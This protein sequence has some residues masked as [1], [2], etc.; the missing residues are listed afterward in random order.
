MKCFHRERKVPENIGNSACSKLGHVALYV[1][2]FQAPR[3]RLRRLRRIVTIGY[4]HVLFGECDSECM[5]QMSGKVFGRYEIRL[6][7]MRKII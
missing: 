6:I 4:Q 1:E 3:Q 7:L 5:K 2:N